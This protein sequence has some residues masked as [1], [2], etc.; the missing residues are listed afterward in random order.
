MKTRIKDDGNA[1]RAFTLIELLVVI[2]IIAILAGLLLPAMTRARRQAEGVAC[3]N[4]QR[5]LIHAWLM[6]AGDNQ[7]RLVGN[8]P[9]SS[10]DIEGMRQSGH[11]LPWALGDIRYGT[12]DSTNIDFVAGQRPDSLNGYLGPAKI[13]LCPSDRSRSSVRGAPPRPRSRSFAMNASLANL[14]PMD[15]TTPNLFKLSDLEIGTSS[16]YVVFIDTHADTIGLC[17]FAQGRFFN[18]ATLWSDRPASRHGGRGTLSYHDG[19]V[20]LTKWRTP[21]V[22]VPET[23]IRLWQVIMPGTGTSDWNYLWERSTKATMGNK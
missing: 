21:E 3:L 18:T 16:R 1:H 6:Y 22:L 8:T 20:E 13:Y 11:P 2:A 9:S 5:Q 15:P 14:L 7:D 17:S 23:G 19:R 12:R 10:P 4:N